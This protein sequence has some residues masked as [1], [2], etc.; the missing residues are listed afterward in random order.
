MLTRNRIVFAAVLL[1]SGLAV[2]ALANRGPPPRRLVQVVDART[3][4]A[5]QPQ[6]LARWFV[7]GRRDFTVVDL[8]EPTAFQAGH[9][10]NAVSCSH[11]HD[12]AAEGRAAVEK[13]DFVDL[14]KKLVVYTETGRESVEL[15]R[16]LARNPR[17][18]LL[19]G[20][21]RGWRDEVLG[22]VSFEGVTDPERLEAL[23]RREALRAF[24][25]GERPSAAP[26]AP[27]PVAPIR[28]ESA[29][30]PATAREGC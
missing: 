26:V 19:E 10:R 24:F 28:R 25:S 2:A 13:G 5:V 12:S 20:G 8:R 11:C 23:G 7:E 22:K 21:Y 3:H 30:K 15:P 29:H 1:V 9:V 4:Q 18:M 16:A 14:S 17:L 6:E 27:L